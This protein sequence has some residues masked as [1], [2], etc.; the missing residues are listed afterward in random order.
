MD[1][2]DLKQRKATPE[3]KVQVQLIGKCN[4]CNVKN[5]LSHNIQ[6]KPRFCMQCGNKINYSLLK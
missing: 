2:K 4:H 1:N 5:I 6:A 3:G